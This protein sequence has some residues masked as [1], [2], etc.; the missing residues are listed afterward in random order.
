MEFRDCVF[1]ASGVTGV[2]RIIISASHIGDEI[3]I[4]NLR[5]VACV[6]TGQHR[7]PGLLVL[8]FDAEVSSN[9]HNKFVIIDVFCFV[10]VFVHGLT[11]MLHAETELGTYS[12]IPET[13]A[14]TTKYRTMTS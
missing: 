13:L 14:I 4:R 7:F 6:E 3:L 9:F 11:A 8:L 1:T 2:S 5:I 12:I 10:Q